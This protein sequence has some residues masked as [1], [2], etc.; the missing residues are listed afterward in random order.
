VFLSLF[1]IPV[2]PNLASQLCPGMLA[3]L[4]AATAWLALAT[5]SLA[6][7]VA[8][9]SAGAVLAWLSDVQLA[10]RTLGTG[11][12]NLTRDYVLQLDQAVWSAKVTR[13]GLP[14]P[15]LFA[16]ALH[17]ACINEANTKVCCGE[18]RERERRGA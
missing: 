16:S 3:L 15:A 18:E 8:A 11:H 14:L 1:I 17:T 4:A 13:T 10:R 2:C 5:L 6:A 12:L 7:P 9:P